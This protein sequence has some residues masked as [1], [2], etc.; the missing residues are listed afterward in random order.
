MPTLGLSPT[1]PWQKLGR[2]KNSLRESSKRIISE[3]GSKVGFGLAVWISQGGY[4]LIPGPKAFS[5]LFWD[6]AYRGKSPDY[7][8]QLC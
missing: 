6:C 5:G 4:S 1:R 3:F 7:L 2:A 8:S